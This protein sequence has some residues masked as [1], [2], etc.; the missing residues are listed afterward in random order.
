MWQQAFSRTE[1]LLG[2]Q[3]ME[4]LQDARVI[5]F[6]LGGVGSYAVEALARTGI[7]TIGLVDFDCIAQSNLN[8]Q[9]FATQNTIG[10]RKTDAALQRIANIA[11][12]VHTEPYPICYD[13][14]HAEQIDLKRYD[15]IIDA[16]DMVSSKL[17]LVER[18]YQTDVPIISA[19][20]TGNK[21]DPTRLEVADLAQ[22]SVCPLARVMRR[23]LKKRGIEHLQV[24]Y[25][26][27]TPR[28]SLSVQ[29]RSNGRPTPGSVAFVP[30]AAGMILASQVV[31]HLCLDGEK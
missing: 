10:Q 26:K 9:L 5:V 17:L 16:I 20:G 19:M 3:A 18:A 2:T 28:P 7:G 21:L 4:R 23:E 14:M 29:T 25:S 22:T 12:W 6:G 30:A 1:Q 8:R 27:E 11:P 24:V 15:Y 13:A 31:H